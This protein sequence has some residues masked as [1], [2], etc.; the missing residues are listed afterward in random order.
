MKASD[1]SDEVKKQPCE[2]CGEPLDEGKDFVLTYSRGKFV[3]L[4]EECSDYL[5]T[6]KKGKRN[7]REENK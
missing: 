1:V 3:A 4:H 7:K 6:G 2:K 5:E